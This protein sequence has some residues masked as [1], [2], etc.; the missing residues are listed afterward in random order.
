MTPATAHSVGEKIGV[1]SALGVAPNTGD[2]VKQVAVSDILEI[3]AS[4]LLAHERADPASN[5][6]QGVAQRK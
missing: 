6:E 2:F 4:K 3:E 5:A 1:N